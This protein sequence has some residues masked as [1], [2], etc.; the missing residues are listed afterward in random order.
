MPI[1]LRFSL[2]ELRGGLRGFRLFVAC[3]A[4]GVAVI[5]GIGTLSSA[6][7]AGLERDGR[8]LLGGDIEFRLTHRAATPEERAFMERQGKVSE[9]VQMRAMAHAVRSDQRTL[10]ELKAVDGAYPLHDS[11]RLGDGTELDAALAV[12]KG[13]F[14]A[15][16]DAQALIRLEA[17]IGDRLDIGEASFEIRA[18]IEREPDRAT[19]GLTLGPRVMI[20]LDALPATRLVQPGSHTL[21]GDDG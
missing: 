4:L 19:D 14:G 16:V 1:S 10:V 17:E 18:V 21:P 3:L 11:V 12:R 9:A 5:A 13:I 2:R 8:S 6:I 7:V 15:A 20:A